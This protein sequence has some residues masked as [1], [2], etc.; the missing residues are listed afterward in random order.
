MAKLL[1]EKKNQI[2][3]IRFNR[4]EALNAITNDEVRRLV[5]VLKEASQDK[6]VK[7]IIL[8]GV[9]KSF[10]A[11]DDLKHLSQEY[12][13][14]KSGKI[15]ITEIVEGITEE[16]QEIPRIIMRAPKVVI[17]AVGGY[18]VG[19]GFE[20]AMDCDLIVAAEDASLDRLRQ[21]PV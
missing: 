17:A 3:W 7:A 21:L 1:Y 9:G 14:L 19:G 11:G 6:E 16:L 18:A 4:P 12:E 8:S 10:C 2:G 20:I 13:D 5:E 15:T